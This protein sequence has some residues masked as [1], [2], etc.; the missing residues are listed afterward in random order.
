M[1]NFG[2]VLFFNP[3]KKFGMIKSNS[4][5]EELYFFTEND[6]K[7]AIIDSEDI[8]TFSVRKGLVDGKLSAFNIT[9]IQ[10]EIVK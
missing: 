2:Q 3:A 9:K 7:N 1:V 6:I 8:V 5:N 4:Q 10:K